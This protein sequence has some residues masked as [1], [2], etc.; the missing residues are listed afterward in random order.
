MNRL[1]EELKIDMGLEAQA[2]DDSNVTG[3]YFPLAEHR[4]VLAILSGGAMAK[5]TT[6]ILQL[7]QATNAEAGSAKVITVGTCT[8]TANELVTELTITLA[9]VL[10]DE[11]I[12]INGLLFTG[13]GTVTTIAD[14]V[15]SIATGDTEAAAELCICINDPTY[16]VPGVTATSN[17]GVVTLKATVPGATVVSAVSTDATFTVATVSAQSYVEIDPLILDDTF[18]HLA[19][20]VTST[21]TGTIAVVLIRGKSRKAISQKVGASYPA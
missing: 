5:A 6:T 16:G 13:H 9:S 14:R 12:T 15:F 19:A 11:T 2:L 1:Y 4:D 21:A 18:T 17:L 8:I 7:M 20:K 10:A 3:D